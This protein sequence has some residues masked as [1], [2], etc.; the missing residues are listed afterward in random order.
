MMPYLLQSFKKQS[1]RQS[2][3]FSELIVAITIYFFIVFNMV[4]VEDNF[5]VGYVAIVCVSLYILVSLLATSRQVY[6]ETRLKLYRI[7][8]RRKFIK[9]RKYRA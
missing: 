4:S 6:R 5:T 1:K 7:F 8:A 2:N 9:Q 3:S